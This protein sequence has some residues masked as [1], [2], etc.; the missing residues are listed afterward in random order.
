MAH[1]ESDGF[2]ST[3][4]KVYSSEHS[5]FGK[6]HLQPSTLTGQGVETADDQQVGRPSNELVILAFC[7]LTVVATISWAMI[8]VAVLGRGGD[9][10]PETYDNDG[11]EGQV[12]LPDPEQDHPVP[13]PVSIDV[14]RVPRTTLHVPPSPTRS[15]PMSVSDTRPATI[16]I[17]T[18]MTVP[19]PS[20]TSTSIST[21]TPAKPTATRNP[22]KTRPL[23]QAL[24]CTYGRLTTRTTKFP[25]DGLCDYIFYDS[26]YKH[27]RDTLTQSY[28]YS[29]SMQTVLAKAQSGRN[30]SKT[31]FGVGFH[32]GFSSAISTEMARDTARNL[33]KPMVA[34]GVSN[35]GVIDVPVYSF[36]PLLTDLVFSALRQLSVYV[37]DIRDQGLASIIVLGSVSST[38]LWKAY[39]KEKFKNS[40]KPDIFISHGYQQ[41]ED[42]ERVPCFVTPPT[43]L[44]KPRQPHVNIHDLYDAM[45]ALAAFG[46]EADAPSLSLSVTMKGRWAEL[47]SNSTPEVFS[48]CYQ[49]PPPL[50]PPRYMD[51][52]RT[53]P[54]SNNL[55][56]DRPHYAMRTYD[57]HT[58]HIFVYDNEQ[59]LCEKLCLAKA[60][61]TQVQFGLAVFDLD[62]ED[63][64]NLCSA[65]NRFGKFSRLNTMNRLLEFFTHQYN[66]RTKEAV[67]S[68]IWRS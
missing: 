22:T 10:D 2:P 41:Y 59:S 60:N 6:S 12:P 11:P 58:G 4:T 62:Y 50:L 7:T 44:T 25:P 29:S 52:C 53:P 48:Q 43:L 31:Q 5:L 57:S 56:Y 26:M 49:K 38:S 61:Y 30:R 67:C 64:D 8:L 66:D 20:M 3:E 42:W 19:A 54:Y 18:N 23:N 1:E 40:F 65:L 16:D 9:V 68:E 14:V 35:F 17:S 21:N 51:L 34:R 45:A 55:A 15:T 36:H 33:L 37:Q 46:V 63:A 27:G 47:L 32:Y 24:L 28:A 39:F 13:Q